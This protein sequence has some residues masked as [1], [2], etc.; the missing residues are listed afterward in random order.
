M[1]AAANAASK[2]GKMLA[3]GLV[4]AGAFGLKAYAQIEQQAV[5]FETLLGSTDKAAR[6]MKQM[7][8]FANV[9]PFRFGDVADSAKLLLAGGWKQDSIIPTL[10]KIGD[11]ASAVSVQIDRVLMQLTKMQDSKAM[12]WADMRVLSQTGLPA[13]DILGKK[14]G[15][16]GDQIREIMSNSGG[17][18]WL[19]QQGGIQK[20]IDGLGERYR[21]AIVRDHFSAKGGWFNPRSGTSVGSRQ[22]R[23]A[24]YRARQLCAG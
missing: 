7:K 8:S 2:L 22:G 16:T 24:Q 9:T 14:L 4:A 21:P 10:T 20:L 11:A 1:H 3:G 23:Y 13:L 18:K 6:L 5:A 17:G 15:K 19:A 12:N